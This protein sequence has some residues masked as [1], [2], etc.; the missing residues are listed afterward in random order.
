MERSEEK[1]YYKIREVAEMTGMAPSALRY[2]ETQFNIIKPTRNAKG[3]RFYTPADV[4][5]IRMVQYLVKEKGLKI[6]AAREQLK[7][8]HAGVSRHA[9]AIEHLKEIR[10]ELVSMLD[11][12]NKLR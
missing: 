9:Q 12:L 2:W 8:N 10:A 5:K 4:E 11:A 6:E 1:K 3:S 7:H